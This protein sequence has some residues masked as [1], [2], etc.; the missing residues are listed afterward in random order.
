MR[1]ASP[2]RRSRS[3]CT[4]HATRNDEADA[5]GHCLEL[6]F[7]HAC[8]A[9]RRH[10]RH[11]SAER[12][13]PAGERGLRVERAQLRGD[14]NVGGLERHLEVLRQD[15]D[16]ADWRPES[17]RCLQAQRA[18]D[19]AR[20]RTVAANPQC[21]TDQGHPRGPAHIVIR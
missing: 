6:G 2:T 10:L 16:D 15:T 21:M 12:H 1:A 14:Q 20:I 13:D 18:F 17:H 9:L 11:K 8:R 19:D 4:R 5:L 3:G 7:E